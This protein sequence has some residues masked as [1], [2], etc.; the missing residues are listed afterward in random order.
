MTRDRFLQAIFNILK[1]IAGFLKKLPYVLEKICNY[2]KLNFKKLNFK[3]LNFK[4]LNFKKINFRQINYKKIIVRAILAVVLLI[5]IGVIALCIM[6]IHGKNTLD[7]SKNELIQGKNIYGGSIDQDIQYNGKK[8]IYKKGLINLLVLGIDKDIPMSMEVTPGDLGQ[9]DALYLVSMDTINNKISVIG[10]PRDTMIPI[11]I[12]SS[13]NSY[14][15]METM[16]ITLQYAYGN[17]SEKGIELTSKAVSALLYDIPI[18]RSLAL[19]MKTIPLINDAIGGVPVTIE[20]DFTDES[21]EIIDQEFVKGNAVTLKGDQALKFV[22][23]RDCSIFASSMDRVSRQEQYIDSF[24]LTAKD[25]LKH[26]LILPI[27]IINKIKKNDY[28]YTD[29]KLSEL[30]YLSSKAL[31]TSISSEDIIT[32]P[33]EVKKGERFEEFYPDMDQVE[34]IILDTFYY[35]M[36]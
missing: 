15:N 28:A 11:E 14:Y 22:R 8:Y 35:Q 25:A 17:T 13:E 12:V 19:N 31:K 6:L 30:V 32:I 1:R 16:Q 33:G 21:G 2:I 34:K 24:V 26:N 27:S 29:L 23:E 4:K 3:K 10:I 5:V 18:Q 36:N 7:S 20:N 9:S